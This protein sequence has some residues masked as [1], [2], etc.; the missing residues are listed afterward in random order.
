MDCGVSFDLDFQ[1]VQLLPTMEDDTYY[2]PE[3][4]PKTWVQWVIHVSCHCPSHRLE[5]TDQIQQN[6]AKHVRRCNGQR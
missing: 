4:Q 3:K 5:Y 1:D 6:W 2:D